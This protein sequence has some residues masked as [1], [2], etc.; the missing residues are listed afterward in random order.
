MG[1]F[2]DWSCNQKRAICTISLY[3]LNIKNFH[4][5]EIALD[6]IVVVVCFL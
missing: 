3:T 1:R 4:T 6:F 5:V 2:P